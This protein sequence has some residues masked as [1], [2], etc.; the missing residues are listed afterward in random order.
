M[1]WKIKVEDFGRIESG[2][3][4][5]RRLT[6]LVGR[7]NSGK[8]YLA[9]L[10]WAIESGGLDHPSLSESE[11]SETLK[12][13]T[14]RALKTDHEWVPWSD[15]MQAEFT[16]KW[17]SFVTAAIPR[18]CRSLFDVEG[19]CPASI[20][21][22]A[23]PLDQRW[24]VKSRYEER[25]AERFPGTCW[26]EFSN[27]NVD[28]DEET[29]SHRPERR[30]FA[31]L[32]FGRETPRVSPTLVHMAGHGGSG[33]SP[34]YD[35]SDSIFLPAAR[36][37]FSL[38]LPTFLQSKLAESLTQ[39]SH[40]V[41]TSASE[42]RLPTVPERAEFT[43]PQ[44]R[45]L[46]ALTSRFGGERG[47]YA[48]EADRLEREC[49]EGVV[50]NVAEDTAS[51]RYQFQPAT[52]EGVS[53]DLQNSSAVVTELLPLIVALRN[54]QR[55][56]FLVIEEP[57]A[58]LHP[59]LQR[60]VA[61]ALCRL[62][63]RGVRVLI[64]THSA[65]IAQQINNLVKLGQLD[66]GVRADLGQKHGYDSEEYLLPDDVSFHEFES[67]PS[68]KTRVNKLEVGRGGFPLPTF[69]KELLALA[70]ETLSLNDSLDSEAELES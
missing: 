30:F 34:R 19:I 12:D 44:V 9:S 43:L 24:F 48:D 63:R 52:S 36:T 68:R 7:N 25:F 58:H 39:P 61:R 2:E 65:T 41:V 4:D 21:I 33:F 13:W 42:V 6:V 22:S 3:V 1:D 18:V 5:V 64:T 16:G 35:S 56:P 38:F 37:G 47:P 62:V 57:E 29:G 10:I 26:N 46:S 60:V 69:N 28:S 54:A 40:K 55:I 27:A 8:S 53:L 66:E 20:E 11:L 51:A 59:R 67:S 17:P 32:E 14:G 70:N 15:E 23:E 45:L 31:F 50:R 49:L